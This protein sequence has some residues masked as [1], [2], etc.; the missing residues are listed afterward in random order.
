M[1]T[2]GAAHLE[3]FDVLGARVAVLVAE[4]LVAG[5]HAVTW[6]GR[7]SEGRIVTSGMYICR[8]TASDGMGREVVS[9]RKM[10]YIR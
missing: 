7:T 5:E 10:A 6:G 1:K 9:T 8:L 4:E 2:A 3:I